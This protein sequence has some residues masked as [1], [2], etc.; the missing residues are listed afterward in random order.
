MTVKLAHMTPGQ[1]ARSG[2]RY[3][4]GKDRHGHQYWL[5]EKP[6]TRGIE[7]VLSVDL[8]GSIADPAGRLERATESELREML[9]GARYPSPPIDR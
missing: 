3:F 4:R 8:H 7:W 6:G 2:R 1:S 9:V 5:L